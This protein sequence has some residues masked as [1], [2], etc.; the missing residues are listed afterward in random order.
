MSDAG[1]IL[2]RILAHKRKLRTRRLVPLAELR[3]RAEAT[4]RPRDARSVLRHQ[5][6]AELPQVIAEYK[7]RSPSAGWLRAAKSDDAGDVSTVAAAYKRAGASMVSVL[8]E[9]AFFSGSLADLARVS[10][11]DLELPALRKDFL[12]DE[13]DLY[14]S[15]L[16]GAA[17]V[18]LIV[19]ALPD[20]GELAALIS[21]AEALGLLPLCE[22]HSAAEGARA[23]TAGARCI[24][25]NHRDLAT[26]RIDLD[27]SSD[28]RR[29]L[30]ADVLLVAESGLR[31]RTDLLLMQRRGMD[32]VLIGEA[33]LREP[34][35]GTALQRLLLP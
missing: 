8:T 9:E 26:L 12:S 5:P 16:Y 35:P 29:E 14:E 33:L 6:G 25:I 27:L 3:R 28:M 4:D 30:G 17:A 18:L 10:H 19:R 23:R 21:L 1:D 34:D 7:R 31:T 2:A 15:R 11:S 13:Y 20:A 22:A 32:A 24:G